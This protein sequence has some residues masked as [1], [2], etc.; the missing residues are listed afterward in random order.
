M[1]EGN[2]YMPALQKASADINQ[3]SDKALLLF[4]DE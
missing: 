3:T 4:T 1:T 2:K